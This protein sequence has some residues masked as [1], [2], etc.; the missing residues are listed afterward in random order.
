MNRDVEARMLQSL[1]EL[2][3]GGGGE[4][5]LRSE[6]GPQCRRLGILVER[7]GREGGGNG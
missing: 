5:R 6:L 7:C 3:S 1:E 4:T 2:E